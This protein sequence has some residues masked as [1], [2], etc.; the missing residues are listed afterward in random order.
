MKL[1]VKEKLGYSLGDLSPWIWV[2][3]NLCISVK[4]RVR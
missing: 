4:L 1:S 3:L 2:N